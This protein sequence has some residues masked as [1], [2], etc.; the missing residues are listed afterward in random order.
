MWSKFLIW[1]VL[2]GAPCTLAEVEAAGTR[3]FELHGLVLQASGERLRGVAPI[4][5]L[6]DTATPFVVQT[7]AGLNGKFRFKNVQ[8]GLYVL[9]IAVPRWGEM[10]QTIEIGPSSVTVGR[11]IEQTFYFKPRLFN[12]ETQTVSIN[13]LSVSRKAVREYRKARDRLS[14][15]DV[16]GAIQFLE[17][18]VALSPQ[19]SEAWNQLGTI[20]Y[21]SQNLEKAESYF[22]EALK[23]EPDSYPPLVNLGGVLLSQGKIQESLPLNQQAVKLRPDDPLAHAQLG[24]NYFLLQQNEGAEKHLKQ[25]KKL[26]SKHFSAPRLVLAELYSQMGNLAAELVELEEFLKF[27]PDSDLVPDIVKKVEQV[28]RSIQCRIDP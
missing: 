16:S 14:K 9:I 1:M 25:A 2:L 18:A 27:H 21:R 12:K 22:Q 6:Q 19:F 13:Q 3:T 15:R 23:Q 20:A 4:V 8:S 11:R 5:F 10:H 7:R 26:D 17:K 24:Y 28:R